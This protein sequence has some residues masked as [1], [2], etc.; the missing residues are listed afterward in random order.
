MN[1]LFPTDYSENACNAFQYACYLAEKMNAT[2][3]LFH[4]YQLPV[5]DSNLPMTTST[6]RLEE[7]RVAQLNK[8]RDFVN[9][10]KTH[11]TVLP[12]DKIELKYEV[13]TGDF[14]RS[15]VQMKQQNDFSF[16]VMGTK[17]ATNSTVAEF[18]S[19]TTSV[20]EK[21]SIPVLAIPSEATYKGFENIALA[22]D[23]DNS[24]K[25]AISFI[26]KIK[27]LFGAHLSVLHIAEVEDNA[28]PVRKQNYNEIKYRSIRAVP[29]SEIS[30][31]H[32]FDKVVALD[33]F[34]EENKVNLLAMV[35]RNQDEEEDRTAKK[36]L[37]K[38]MVL[39]ANVPLIVFPRND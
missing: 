21:S 14:L 19:N 3:T 4:V 20:I 10:F 32:G 7:V 29:D 30:I 25:D 27:E 22:E 39:H 33:E 23:F 11:A 28:N 37:V 9:N 38:E 6:H 17:G 1:I 31:I 34:I 12:L 2:L 8:L 5:L 13:N 36:S 35:V 24:D 18:G 15:I 26:K 16:I